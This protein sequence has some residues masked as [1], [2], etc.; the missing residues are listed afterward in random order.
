M[1]C[2]SQIIIS[3]VIYYS[4]LSDE[5]ELVF[6]TTAGFEQDANLYGTSYAKWK[7]QV[8]KDM[9]LQEDMNRQTLKDM[10]EGNEVYILGLLGHIFSWLRLWTCLIRS[11]FQ[12]NLRMMT[13]TKSTNIEK[14]K[15]K[16]MPKRNLTNFLIRPRF[17]TK[18][19]QKFF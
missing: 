14:K 11:I 12:V 3:E 5:E 6:S 18:F 15:K 17:L 1:E 8:V 19:C 4:F 9:G 16:N 2:K 7:K 10:G 13:S